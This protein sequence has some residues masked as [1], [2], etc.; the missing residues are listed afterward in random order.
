MAETLALR[1]LLVEDDLDIAAGIG[2]YLAIHGIEVDFAGSADEAMHVFGSHRFDVLI[3]DLQLP[4]EDGIGLCR[5]LKREY[6]DEVPVIFLTAHGALDDKLRAFEAGAI[7][8]VVKPFEP[9]ELLA[10]IRAG[11]ARP[12]SA[13][14]P[15]LTVGNYRLDCRG[16]LLHRGHRQLPLTSLAVRLLQQLMRAHPGFVSRERLCQALWDGE[17][18]PSDPLRAHVH[19]LRRQLQARFG[20]PL[21]G[22]LRGVGYRFEVDDDDDHAASA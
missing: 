13:A 11:C 3:L 14:A 1:A 18:P 15:G 21:I 6:G 7:D 12:A 22:T 4:G 5:R 19:Q 9:A 8:Y 17:P 10:R 2:E 20:R 16:G